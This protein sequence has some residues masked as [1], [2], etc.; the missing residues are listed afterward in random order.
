MNTRVISG[1]AVAK[2]VAELFTQAN[3]YLPPDTE[4]ALRAAA[5]TETHAIAA[6]CLNMCLDN[7]RAA[8]EQGL[9]ICQDTGL[10]CVYCEKGAFAAV[11]GGLQA[12]V[13][14]GVRRACEDGCLR[15]SMVRDPLRR[16]NTGDNTPAALYLTEVPGD[17][18]TLTVMPKGF[19]SENMTRLFMLDPSA[20]REDVIAK[21]AEAAGDAGS[22]PCP[23]VIVGAGLGGTADTCLAL[24]KRQLLRAAGAP[25]ADPYYAAMERDALAAVNA[26][27]IGAQG[28]GG[29][30]TALAVHIAASPTHIAG[31]PL[32]VAV[33]C[34]VTRHASAVI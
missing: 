4:A 18:L 27:G 24:A 20:S 8:R 26:L 16:E 3:V 5:R 19:G 29:K 30:T 13:N 6:F 28:M 9:P 14:E 10:C 2:A 34:W 31:L 1:E 33:G 7:A 11:H 17:K 15:A 21:I 12:A 25:S 23:P 22:A 32:G